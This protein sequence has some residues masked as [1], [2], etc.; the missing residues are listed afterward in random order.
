MKEVIVTELDTN[1]SF[2]ASIDNTPE[3]KQSF[4]SVY[5]DEKEVR[6][7]T[8]AQVNGV[9]TVNITELNDTISNFVTKWYKMRKRIN[10]MLETDEHIYLIKGCSIKHFEAPDKTFTIFYNTFKEA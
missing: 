5:V 4:S 3:V 2:K 10:L 8:V 6:R 1:L 9:L 7:P